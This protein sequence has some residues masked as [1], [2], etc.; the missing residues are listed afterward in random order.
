[1]VFSIKKVSNHGTRDPIV[2]RLAVQSQ[3]VVDF[4][5]ISDE[6]R[7]QIIEIFIDSVMPRLLHCA[8]IYQ[9]INKENEEICR[10]IERNEINIQSDERVVEVPQISNLKYQAEEFLYHAKSTLR[11]LSLGFEPLFG[12]RFNHSNFSKIREWFEKQYGHDAVMVEF[13]KENE[14]WIKQIIDCRNAVEHPDTGH[15]PLQIIN[16]ELLFQNNQRRT[17]RGP[18]WFLNGDPPSSILIDMKTTLENLL[19]FGEDLL[20]VAYIQMGNNPIIQF[21]EIPEESRNPDCPVRLRAIIDK[22]KLN[23]N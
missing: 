4:F 1:M 12:V 7:K 8:D 16:V 18:V 17:F 22:S 5:C 2:A 21:S 10:K 15:G 9:I 6:K 3:E 23:S 14:P 11:N 19:T 13:L 20:V